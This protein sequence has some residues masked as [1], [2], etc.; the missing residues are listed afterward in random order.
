[1]DAGACAFIL[2]PASCGR[3]YRLWSRSFDRYSWR[4]S[5]HSR[6]LPSSIES[7]LL[8]LL[9]RS[10]KQGRRSALCPKIG[11]RCLKLSTLFDYTTRK[12]RPGAAR[13]LGAIIVRF[14]MHDDAA[15]HDICLAFVHAH[16]AQI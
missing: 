6:S 10:K 12:P 2:L 16:P 7:S 15:A 3:L 5:A 8:L 14:C 9:D 4:A 11:S 13:R 1:F